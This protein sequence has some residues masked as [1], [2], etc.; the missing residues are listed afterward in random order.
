[1]ARRQKALHFNL[2]F[3]ENVVFHREHRS[4][5]GRNKINRANNEIFYKRKR[6]LEEM[7]QGV[8]KYSLR[9]IRER[10]KI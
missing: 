6:L 2:K 9:L 3:G 10:Y 4:K 1:M 8:D 7:K 5:K